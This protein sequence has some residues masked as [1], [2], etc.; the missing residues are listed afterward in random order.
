VYC[1]LDTLSRCFSSSIR[2][3]LNELPASL[4]ETYEKTLQG[5]AREKKDHAHRLFQCL[6]AAVRPLRVDELAEI[7]AV[8][9]DPDSEPRLEEGWRP[10]NPEEA[11]LSA[12]S[13]LITI[14]GDEDSKIVQFSHFSVKEFLTSERF[15]TSELGKTLYIPLDAAHTIL[16]RACLTVLLQLDEKLDKQRLKTFPLAPYAA[17]YWV[18]HAKIENVASQSKD[19][20][21]RLFN[22][23]KPHLI[24]WTRIYNIDKG[25]EPSTNDLDD[26]EERPSPARATSLYYAA[27]CGFAGVA[28]YL[29]VTHHENVNVECGHHGT[30][31][32]A[33]SYEGH[34]DAA[35]LLVEHNADVKMMDKHKR[36][37][38][39]SAYDG[40]RL[41]VMQMLLQHGANVEERY[42]YSAGLLHIASHHGQAEVVELLL[43]N[44]A[45][46]NARDSVNVT[47]LH[48]A[49][50][51]G[52]L[53]VVELLLNEGADVNAETNSH[54][55]PLHVASESGQLEVVRKLLEFGAD[56][57]VR[58]RR[59]RSP[60]DVA[61]SS[62]HTEVANLLAERA[63]KKEQ[64]S[65]SKA[66]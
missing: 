8:D 29:I 34:V 22:P 63:E 57:H 47:P 31:L 13:T 9:F 24:A 56:V 53:N 58:N 15:Q 1:Q 43:R 52:H 30:P 40:G 65:T 61:T 36:T 5:I 23:K 41:E 6:V 27:L 2:K 20:M 42:A 17:R 44:K 10:E 55:T 16:T 66:P 3:A 11:V 33:A 60:F 45:D 51:N 38:L 14:I 59:N 21:Q 50:T 46:A 35:R 62:G 32:H 39:C 37:A 4:D 19:P 18:D 12:C 28:E 64:G 54:S 25:N 7:F 26:N 48:G 49:S